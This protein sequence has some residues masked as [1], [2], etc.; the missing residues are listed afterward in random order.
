MSTH[1]NDFTH[2]YAAAGIAAM[3]LASAMNTQALD[4][5][6]AD[7]AV[8]IDWDTSLNYGLQFRVQ[9]ANPSPDLAKSWNTNDGTYNFDPGIVSNKFTIVSE[10]DI[11]WRNLGFFIRGKALYDARYMN[12]DTDQT[13]YTYMFDNSGTGA[14][15]NDA[16]FFLLEQV[17]TM[18]TLPKGEFLDATKGIHG[19][20]AFLM[21]AFLYGDFELAGRFLN[22]RLGSQVITWGEAFFFPG[23]SGAQSYVDASAAAAPGTQV[24]E[25]FLPLGALYGNLELNAAISIEAYYQYGWEPVR[26]AGVGSYWSNADV[27]GAGAERFILFADPAVIPVPIGPDVDPSAGDDQWGLALRWFLEG[28]TE[29]GFYSIRYNDHF[30]S[31][32]GIAS[33]NQTGARTDALPVG[34]NDVYNPGQNMYAVSFSTLVGGINV[35]GELNYSPNA[36]PTQQ[37]VRP[38][39]GSDGVYRIA[40]F[41]EAH[42]T[43]ANLGVFQIW[44]DNFISDQINLI[45]ELSYIRSNLDKE[46]LPEGQ[47]LNDQDAWGVAINM[48][49]DYK[50]VMSGLDL[51]VLTAFKYAAGEWKDRA[52][53]SHAREAAI[54]LRGIYIADWTFDIKYSVFWGQSLTNAKHDRDNVSMSVGYVF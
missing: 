38:I 39:Q 46:D 13:D 3:A 53:T 17:G 1:N 12:Q 6:F 25:I 45:G 7:G 4:F 14:G 19:Q 50:S 22:V 24:K 32:A 5:E 35:V 52:M 41:Q 8:A 18:G 11:Q 29:F 28:G 33:P 44:G 47:L 43:Q 37:T 20:D 9:S 36:L 27:S 21:D 49:F 2:K 40:D 10:A 54:G 23:I 15:L 16:G 51:K 42:I 34:V 31:V 48:D 30:P 26:Q